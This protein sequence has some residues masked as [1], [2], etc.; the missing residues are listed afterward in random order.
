MARV[1]DGRGRLL[2][3]GLRSVE[4][5]IYAVTGIDAEREMG[6][7]EYA[8]AMAVFTLT[9]AGILYAIL[10]LQSYL[11]LNPTGAASASRRTRTG[12]AMPGNR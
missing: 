6:W 12:R 7:R 3:W 8:R 1:Y 11:P 9:G 2:P 5:A 10:R 4:R